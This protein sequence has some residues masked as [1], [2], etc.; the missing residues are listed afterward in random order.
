[1][2]PSPLTFGASH[3]SAMESSVLADNTVVSS[4]PDRA[5]SAIADDDNSLVFDSDFVSLAWLDTNILETL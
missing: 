3:G 2:N 5:R 4:E 1:M